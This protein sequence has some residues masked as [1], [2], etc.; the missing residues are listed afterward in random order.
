MDRYTVLYFDINHCKVF[1]DPPPRVMKVKT[2]ETYGI[3]LNLKAFAQQRR[4]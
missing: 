3:Q 2:K 4:P 1:F